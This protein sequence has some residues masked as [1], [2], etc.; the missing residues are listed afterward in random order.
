MSADEAGVDLV[1]QDARAKATGKMRYS[2]DLPLE[3]VLHAVV[4][5]SPVPH[6]QIVSIESDAAR[7]RDGVVAVV[8][9]AELGQVMAGRR[10][11]DMPVLAREETRFTGEGIAVALGTSREVAESA[12]RL[13]AIDYQEL[14][15]VTEP[16]TA[17]APDSARVHAA[18]SEYDGAVVSL[19]DPPNLQS[20]LVDGSQEEVDVALASAAHVVTATYRT[21]AGHQGY[22]EPICWTAIPRQ[23]GGILLQG[24]CKQPYQVRTQVAKALGV[25]TDLVEVGPMPLGGDF[26]GKGGMLD[27]TL[28]AALARWAGQPVRLALRSD[29]DLMSTDARHGSTMDV[30]LGCDRDGRLVGLSLDALLDGGAY[31][32]S[33][34]IPSVNLHGM[35]EAALGYRLSAF[36]VRSRIVYTHTVP[37]G[38]MRAP[39]APQAVF[40]IESAMDELAQKVRIP[41]AELRRRNLLHSGERDAYGHQWP[42]ARGAITLDAALDE[43]VRSKA[44]NKWRTG[45]GMALYARPT[46]PPGPTSLRLV[47]GGDGSFVVELPFPDTGTGSHSVVGEEMAHCL[48]VARDRVIV[49]QVPTN[50]LPYDLGVGGSWVTAGVSAA[51]R[52]LADAWN[53]SSKDRPVMV[54]TEPEDGP[55]ALAYCAQVAHVA[56]DPETGQVR[57]LELVTAVDVAQV[58]RPRSH[59][60]QVDGGAVMGLGFAL[61]EDLLEEGGQVWASNFAEFRLPTAE[62]V[63]LLRT[64][65]VPGG[66]GVGPANVKSVGELSNVPTAAAVANAVADAVGAR[67][68][69]LPITAESVYWCLEEKEVS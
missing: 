69:Q 38:H 20:E 31:A 42:E 51:I 59:R 2:A 5:R 21:Q 27:A 24:T 11:R 58:L 47:G 13:V 3:G 57:V 45:T 22:L 68:R 37:K 28:C 23:G 63:P 56:V 4:V 50:A 30:R 39:G 48:G 60:L 32:A 9:G 65:L 40:A 41:A 18:A 14:P 8:T 15:A 43:P 26:G 17:L 16:A 6:A 1:R 33:K 67:V 61:L 46:L 19:S 34:P 35:A 29:E 53:A 10:V 25:P 44:P 36:Y 49:R 54:A 62:D 12:A 55:A 66:T 7:A 64:V 52:R